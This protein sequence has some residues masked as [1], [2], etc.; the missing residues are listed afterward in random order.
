[1]KFRPKRAVG[2]AATVTAIIGALV[3]LSGC[4]TSAPT[5][6]GSADA[7]EITWWGWTPELG[8]GQKYIEAFNKEYPDIKVTYK[9][10]AT[11]DYDS[12]IRPALA[13]NVG[14]DV[15]NIAPGG[16]IGSIQAYGDF[17][18]D[19]KPAVEKALGSDWESKLVPLGPAGLTD[20]NGRLAALP[21]GST[22]AGT[23]WINPEIFE[24]YGQKVP[25]TLDEWI[26]TCKAFQ[27]QGQVCFE[28]GA[29]D[30]GFNQDL[31]HSIA[32]SIEPG[33]WNAAVEGKEEWTNPK[34]VQ[35]FTIYSEMF[36]NG[37]MQP[38]AL[39]M[40]QYPDVNNDFI[41]GKA[42]MVLMGTWYM[43]YST[44]DS[45]TAAVNAS[46]VAGAKPFAIV[47]AD[48]PDMTGDGNPA[49]LF[50]DADFGVAVSAKSKAPE[51][52]TTF[53]TWLTTSDAAQQIV[54]NAL[55][56]TPSLA[57]IAPKWDDIEL[58]DAAQQQSTLADL[59]DRSNSVTEPRLGDVDTATGQALGVAIGAIASK[60]ETP[61]VALEKLASTVAGS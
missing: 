52:A 56:D 44:V 7:G 11:A 25:T 51:A 47:A 5:A 27:E 53:V 50:G 20:K 8:V 30:N 31:I 45:A 49:P 60:S 61:E 48:F 12:A 13:S 6:Q 16:G 14:P 21:V 39:G 36:D 2:R 43:Q 37:I 22:F 9:Q 33:L 1:M 15:F 57:S 55:N 18:I 3:A 38:G 42:A 32:D 23:M 19:L 54:A 35:A 26:S 40:Q 59:I 17:A 4:G 28:H 41:S 29:A 34:L 24:K 10:V 46:G 58:V